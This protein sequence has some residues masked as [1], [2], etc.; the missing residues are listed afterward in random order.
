MLE[1]HDSETE[2]MLFMAMAVVM[3]MTVVDLM[4]GGGKQ[5]REEYLV[6]LMVK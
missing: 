2:G 6:P 5:K 1:R 4:G 3:M